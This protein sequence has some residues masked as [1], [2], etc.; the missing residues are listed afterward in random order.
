MT[1]AL[2]TRLLWFALVLCVPLPFFLVETG[3]EPVAALVQKLGVTIQFIAAEG[4][5]GA[6]SLV[7][8]MLG[9]QALI[10]IAVLGLVSITTTRVL[11]RLA[12]ARGGAVVFVLIAA[13]FAV[14]LTQPIYRTPFRVAALHA[15]LAEVF[16]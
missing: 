11:D 12:G 5:S 2:H 13:L 6:A 4:G 7:A 16:E 14:A 10:G 8:W 15:T 1:R 9:V 3:Y